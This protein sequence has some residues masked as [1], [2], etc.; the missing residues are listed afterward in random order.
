MAD[1]H[2]IGKQVRQYD[3]KYPEDCPSCG[4]RVEDRD[5]FQQC[6]EP[7]RLH[8][9]NTFYQEMVSHMEELD[10]ALTLQELTLEAL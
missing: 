8:W 6:H 9:R 2:P 3:K 5:H 1:I 10:T 7:K 4:H